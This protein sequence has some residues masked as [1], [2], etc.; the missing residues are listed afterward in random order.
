MLRIE[1]GMH[2]DEIGRMAVDASGRWLVTASRD[3]TAR[4]WD[5]TTGTLIQTLRP[6]LNE[7]TDGA[8]YT[9]ALS[10]GA[11]IVAV[12]G[13]TGY[14]WDRSN[15]IYLF[16][17]NV[18]RLT[19]RIPGLSATV[20]HLAFSGDGRYLV[21]AL[22]TGGLRVMDPA[23]GR[24]VW[25]DTD[26][27]DFIV[28]LDFD[29]AG[30]LLVA[31]NDGQVRVYKPGPGFGVLSKLPIPA[32]RHP[33]SARFSPTGREIAVAYA[34]ANAVDVFSTDKVALLL[35]ADAAPA[36]RGAMTTV[37][38]SRDGQWLYAAGSYLE[39]PGADRTDSGRNVVFAWPQA[40]RGRVLHIPV[41]VGDILDLRTLPGGAFAVG[42]SAPSWSVVS[43]AGRV[44]MGQ[45]APAPELLA[46]DSLRL[47]PD[48]TV[49]ELEE[50][51]WTESA[52]R[53]L[54]FRFD[55]VRRTLSLDAPADKLLTVARTTGLPLTG[56]DTGALKLAGA[57]VPL[58][59][60]EVAHSVAIAGDASFFAVG[61]QWS[62]RVFDRSGKP[63]WTRD[64]QIVPWG[65][66]ISA[67]RRF[68]VAAFSDGTI[69]WHRASDGAEQLGVFFH[70]D[71][72]RWVAWTPEG[73]FDA[74]GGG[75]GL[76][77][78]HLNEGVDREATFVGVA[79]LSRLFYRPD[80]VSQRLTPTGEFATQR[81]LAAM[82]DVRRV[83]AGGRPPILELLSP[84]E[85]QSVNGEFVLQYRVQDAG[86]GI[87]RIEYR[88]DGQV[89]EGRPEGI[90]VPGQS[91]ISRRFTLAP[92][93][94]EV[95][96]T[97]FNTD[98]TIQARGVRASV[99][100]SSSVARPSLY[101]LAIGITEYRSGNLR[102]KYAAK[103]A[104]AVV[105]ELQARAP[106]LYQ[107]VTIKA[108]YDR[109]ATKSSIKAAFDELSTSVKATDTFVL[110]MAGHGT[111]RDGNY[112]FLPA[113][114]MYENEEALTQQS[115]SHE[116]LE[117][118]LKRIVAGKQLILLDTCSAGAFTGRGLEEQA[119]LLR[120][121]KATGR[122]VLGAASSS[123]MALEGHEGHGV[124][125]WA[126]LRAL[127]GANDANGDRQVD[128]DE[129]A[130]F[131]AKVVPEVTE[132][133]WNYAQ[134]PLRDVKGQN[135]A[136][137]IIR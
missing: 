113:D 137:T 20:S 59:K 82:T 95:S 29:P 120:L 11:D 68:V 40:G 99:E 15:S 47:S 129:I 83:L 80:L 50:A 63:R 42:T 93:R 37:A 22:G 14:D 55:G 77:G 33:S 92:G 90:G 89:L 53:S 56:L 38:W 97:A 131:V 31:S 123:Q 12:A 107:N 85:T 108:L 79:Q 3:K 127:N 43:N 60:G 122:A 128:V 96:V 75:E 19:R 136:V 17:R 132:R 7:G 61:A 67:D 30:R 76:V 73:F 65:V 117:A 54:R 51:I 4:V 52:Y 6:P 112:L 74:G 94:H 86:G 126:L 116:W 18:G 25:Q 106:G 78:W 72:R 135:F 124:F 10:P 98:G 133:R 114:L 118:Q 36:A 26:L 115:L 104:Q 57:P 87:G 45:R 9:V 100:V 1:A 69:R 32:G 109:D 23:A 21:A 46:G 130:S 35:S 102:L 125:T 49:V 64:T 111:V 28:S 62:L 24:E 110:Y 119:A 91:P 58:K 103:D 101:A 48:G 121:S 88:V 16:D 13:W 41:S 71:T 81:A 66:N 39:R 44:L 5:L 27:R 105:Q 8:L 84:Q 34:D 70:S 2:V 134:T